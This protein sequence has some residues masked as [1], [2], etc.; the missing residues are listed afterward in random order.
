ML[1]FRIT[2]KCDSK[3]TRQNPE[4]DFVTQPNLLSFTCSH[5]QLAKYADFSGL[6][7]D[8]TSFIQFAISGISSR[9]QLNLKKNQVRH[10]I[11]I[12]LKDYLIFPHP[13]LGDKFL[14]FCFSGQSTNLN[15]RHFP[16]TLSF[17]LAT[18]PSCHF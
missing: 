3:V 17:W 10:L 1:F 8:M 13:E 18:F 11:L 9:L 2:N 6:N 15:E 4:L 5:R 7:Q 12:K 16:C 14:L